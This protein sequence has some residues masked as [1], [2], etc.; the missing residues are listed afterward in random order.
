VT[1]PLPAGGPR[2]ALA[3]TLV[4][5]FLL[6]AAARLPGLGARGLGAA[7]QTAF[8]E[9]QGFRARV[10]LPI[11]TRLTAAA[12][13]RRS[14]LLE[15]GRG[16]SGPPLHAVGLAL[17]TRAAGTSE[18]A[19]R[20]PSELAGAMAA[21]L[22]ALI[23]GQIAG[24][25]AAAWAGGLVA[26]S[27]IHTL[28]SRDAGPEAPLVFL[29]LASLALALRVE[30][31]GDRRAAVLLGLPLSLLAS[32]GVA[33]FA[34]MALLPPLWLL[35]RPDRRVAAAV[36][37][38]VAAAIAVAVA[39]LGLA[40]SP[41]DF[42][43][44]PAWI[45]EATVSGILRCAGASFTRVAGLEYHLAVSHARYV[46]P[47]TA[48]F[49]GL[50]AWGAARLPARP[51]ELLLAGA[52]LPFALGATLAL[53][54]GRVTPLQASRLLAGL[55]FVA[56]LMAVGLA[57]LRGLRAWATGAAAFG[58]LVSFLTLALAR[59][60]TETSPTQALAREVARCRSGATVVAV[61]RPLDLLALAAWDVPGPFVLR[62]VR[63]PV[64]DGPTIVVGPSSACVGGGAA[65]D[66][67]PA[68]PSR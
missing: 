7:E 55:P 34:A 45:P 60:D 58:A 14:G 12:L 48:L 64:S 9:S 31:S 50:M 20:T 4:G 19:L 11:D 56:V 10:A 40:R 66:A 23:A 2:L 21:A 33:A 57:S 27:P 65:C 43:E 22:A 54:T 26:L 35:R 51:R 18:T 28:A 61:E 24:P 68:C 32:S 36:A 5:C 42:G 62:A 8:V 52:L 37:M 63:A 3:A 39:V 38:G 17:W 44:I 30:S 29:L 46:I 47:L 13:P 41:L 67:L 15:V 6:A 25:W 59:P 49:V 16:A 53:A 1:S